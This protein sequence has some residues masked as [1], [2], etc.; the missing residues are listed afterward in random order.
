MSDKTLNL[1]RLGIL[2][3]IV[4]ASLPPYTKAWMVLGM[5]KGCQATAKAA[6]MAGMRLETRAT[7][8][9]QS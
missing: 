2:L 5:A 3:L 4:V 1:I 6:G 8:M 7:E 9:V